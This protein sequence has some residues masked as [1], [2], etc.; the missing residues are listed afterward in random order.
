MVAGTCF[1]RYVYDPADNSTRLYSVLVFYDPATE[2][3]YWCKPGARTQSPSACLPLRSISDIYMGK[4]DRSFQS[5][6]AAQSDN[7]RCF[8]LIS[9]NVKLNLEATED[10]DA[11]QWLSGVHGILT[12]KRKSSIQGGQRG[13][14]GISS[15]TASLDALELDPTLRKIV[16]LMCK[17]NDFTLYR[18]D[19]N[20]NVVHSKVFVF[21][22]D[23]EDRSSSLG[24]LYWCKPNTRQVLPG[25]SFPLES[26]KEMTI[27]KQSP[28]LQSEEAQK[29]DQHC[30]FSIMGPSHSLSLEAESRGKL[31]VWL[32]G[33]HRLLTSIKS[34]K[35]Q[36]VRQEETAETEL[37]LSAIHIFKQYQIT[38]E[39]GTDSG[40]RVRGC[41]VSYRPDVGKLGALFWCDE[42]R[43]FE[44]R[45]EQCM[46]L[47]TITE[48]CLGKQDKAYGSKSGEEA[49][50]SCCFTLYSKVSISHDLLLSLAVSS[51]PRASP[52]IS[53]LS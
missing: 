44:A 28:V 39:R 40:V 19:T 49:D 18:L 3:I 47:H 7:E 17:G 15:I 14:K 29:A 32:N 30:C 4:R 21:L 52:L 51:S 25:C 43:A 20:K 9:K 10:R 36:K 13:D 38:G 33:I 6:L 45:E 42:G 8:S 48:L 31:A 11:I 23:S 1:K 22:G 24:T 35:M 5:K 46:P 34:R 12:R 2:S 41:Q 16:R 27:G 53:H 50:P 26:I 37:D